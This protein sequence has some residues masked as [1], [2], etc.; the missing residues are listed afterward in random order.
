[1]NPKILQKKKENILRKRYI[2]IS[3]IVALVLI[4]FYCYKK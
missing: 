1:M 2:E 4:V 3:I